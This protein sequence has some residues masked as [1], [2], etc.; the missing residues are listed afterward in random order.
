MDVH[1]SLHQG[2]HLWRQIYEQLR[3]AI[4]DGRLRCGD[5]LPPSRELAD[6][7]T[8][9]RTTINTAYERLTGDGFR[10]SDSASQVR[11]RTGFA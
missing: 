3:A 4:I 9:S 7:L 2:S 11:R 8:V 1:V 10:T 6:R 5:P